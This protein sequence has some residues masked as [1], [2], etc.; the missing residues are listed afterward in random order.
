VIAPGPQAGGWGTPAAATRS[1]FYRISGIQAARR[2][3][4]FQGRSF[5][6][7]DVKGDFGGQGLPLQKR[8]RSG[9]HSQKTLKTALAEFAS[10]I[11]L[12]RLRTDYIG[13]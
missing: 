3:K 8:F 5:V 2:P 13:M 4:P 12:N 7:I 6:T 1:K 11:I 9:G 10:A